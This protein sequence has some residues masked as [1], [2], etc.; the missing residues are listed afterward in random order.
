MINQEILAYI[1]ARLENGSSREEIKEDLSGVGWE[2]ED[3]VNGF[4]A[5][6]GGASLQSPAVRFFLKH[7][8]VFLSLG[9]FVF[10]I[11]MLIYGGSS[12]EHPARG[13]DAR[14]KA[15]LSGIRA[16]AELS[17]D[18]IGN[19]NAVCGTN[20]REQ[21]RA[22]VNAIEDA[23]QANEDGSVVCGR[24]LYGDADAYAISA[25][26]RSDTDEYFCIDSTGV[27]GVRNESIDLYDTKC[28]EQKFD[29]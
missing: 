2:T 25:Q 21:N 13:S 19:Y 24:P 27:A 10:M 4:K 16:Q 15:N 8:F 1:T 20:G 3:I 29:Y 14:I 12:G 23:D 18:D 11:A 9:I 5:Y 28:P 6:D 17:W 26:L 7:I 22:I